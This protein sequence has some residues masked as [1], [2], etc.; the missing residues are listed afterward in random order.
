MFKPF[1]GSHV[2]FLDILR[3]T[4]Y[5]QY[6]SLELAYIPM[7]LMTTNLLARTSLSFFT[8]SGR[9]NE[10]ILSSVDQILSK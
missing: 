3:K 9:H 7:D 4:M 6:Y 2:G 5:G 1:I 8:S 10:L